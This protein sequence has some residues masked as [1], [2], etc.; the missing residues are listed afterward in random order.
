MTPWS[1]LGK[2]DPSAPFDPK[3]VAAG[4]A[5]LGTL[6]V[7]PK[8]LIWRF[9]GHWAA[10]PFGCL[11]GDY[12]GMA[13]FENGQ[14]V[15][16]MTHDPRD[17]A[18][19]L[20]SNA[21]ASHTYMRNTGAVGFSLAGMSGA[22]VT[23]FGDDGVT[24]AGLEYFC[25]GCAAFAVQYD[26]DAL[27]KSVQAPYANEPIFLSHSEAA[28]LVGNPPQYS[29]YGP[30]PIGDVE[31]IDFA[32]LTPLPPGVELTADMATTCGDALR[33]RIHGYKIELVAA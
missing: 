17:N 16:K 23:N 10:A 6:P 11:F 25:V 15:L 31:R 22:T 19:G 30:K 14:W 13:D 32:T 1:P 33:L 29:A 21:E 7:I 2:F 20:N 18:P 28:N 4:K 9:Y 5:F 12:N 26:L 24:L 8:G 27:G 3:I